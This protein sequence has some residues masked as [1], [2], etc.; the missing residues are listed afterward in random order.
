[1]CHIVQFSISLYIFNKLQYTLD[2]IQRLSTDAFGGEVNITTNASFPNQC[3]I[4]IQAPSKPTRT[5]KQSQTIQIKISNRLNARN[6]TRSFEIFEYISTLN[7]TRHKEFALNQTYRFAV[8]DL[9]PDTEYKWYL[10]NNQT[11]GSLF[12]RDTPSFSYEFPLPGSGLEIGYYQVQLDA[13]GPLF[14][15]GSL[16]ISYT[17]KV[18]RRDITARVEPSVVLHPNVNT[19]LQMSVDD[20]IQGAI[21][22]WYLL[23]SSSRGT[24]AFEKL[25]EGDYLTSPV[26]VTI[27]EGVHTLMVN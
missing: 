20:P 23:D 26:P 6:F 19:T 10:I 1:M 13:S 15:G 4:S 14:I 2:G 17:A 11:G 27:G 9:L 16:S 8:N 5:T 21:Y 24:T 12:L 18:V 25:G 22:T 7:V 3:F